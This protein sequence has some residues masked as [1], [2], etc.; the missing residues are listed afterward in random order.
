MDGTGAPP[1]CR[2]T[3]GHDS[4]F[5]AGRSVLAK[6]AGRGRGGIGRRDGATRADPGGHA[7]RAGA[8]QPLPG[9]ARRREPLLL[10]QRRAAR[11]PRPGDAA[12]L[13]PA[14][15]PPL[16][17]AGRRV[18]PRRRSSSASGAA[19]GVALLF[20][21]TTRPFRPL[22]YAHV[23]LV[24]LAALRRAR[25]GAA[26]RPPDRPGGRARGRD[27]GRPPRG[28]RGRGARGGRPLPAAPP[29][30]EPGAAPRRPWRARARA[31]GDRSSPR[32]ARRARA[33]RCPRTSS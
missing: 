33:G 30:R 20:T 13:G 17:R 28:R 11:R 7:A 19:L 5:P 10:R 12:V 31:S 2:R 18:A 16:G 8:Q 6:P 23:A 21:G 9:R 26:P 27:R 4:R 1:G 15:A 32:R 25:G 29:H 24:A 14:G 3:R 22:L